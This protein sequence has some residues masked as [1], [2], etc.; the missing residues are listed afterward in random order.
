MWLSIGFLE[1]VDECCNTGLLHS[2]GNDKITIYH[3]LYVDFE[4]WIKD[5]IIKN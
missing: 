4:D 2:S 5:F 1:A 3:S